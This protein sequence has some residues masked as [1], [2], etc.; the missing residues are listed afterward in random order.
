MKTVLFSIIAAL[1]VFCTLSIHSENQIRKK[2]AIE[3]KLTLDSLDMA[4]IQQGIPIQIDIPES[5][6]EPTPTDIV[7]YILSI[8]GGILTGI[9][10]KLLHHWF[11]QWFPSDSVKDYK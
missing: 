1:L 2:T 3:T 9:I 4:K 11:P 10:L 5:N 7:K 6:Q 8:L